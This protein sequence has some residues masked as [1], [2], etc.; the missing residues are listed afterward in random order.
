MKFVFLS[1]AAL[2]ISGTFKAETPETIDLVDIR[3]YRGRW[4]AEPLDGIPQMTIDK[5]RAGLRTDIE[6]ETYE[7]ALKKVMTSSSHYDSGAGP[8]TSLNLYDNGDGVGHTNALD[9]P[10]KDNG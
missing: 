2:C 6:A 1:A 10:S 7:E 8:K 5:A 3:L 9:N 4:T